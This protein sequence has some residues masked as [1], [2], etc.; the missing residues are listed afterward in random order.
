MEHLE[1]MAKQ[2]KAVSDPNRLKLLACLKKGELCACDFV[3]VLNVSQPAVSQQLKK[4]KEAEIIVE[5]SSGTWKH[6]R[7]NDVL[8]PYIQTIIDH[9]EEISIIKHQC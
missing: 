6:Y 8:P 9:L 7:L 4:L 3:D 2:L 1:V 5:R